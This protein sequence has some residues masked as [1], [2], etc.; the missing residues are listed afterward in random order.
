[1]SKTR[2]HNDIIFVCDGTPVPNAGE[3]ILMEGILFTLE[4]RDFIYL[5]SGGRN[6]KIF[7]GARKLINVSI[8]QDAF[9]EVL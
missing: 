2:I 8:L 7:F 3:R 9:T 1:M 5:N 6:L 4:S